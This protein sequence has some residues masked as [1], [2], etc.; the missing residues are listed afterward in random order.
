VKARVGAAARPTRPWAARRR[1]LTGHERLRPEAFAKM[2]NSLID[3]GDAGVQIMQSY[4]VKE[5]RR[6][7]FALAGTNPE[8]HIFRTCLD[9]FYQHAGASGAP[10]AHRLAATIERWWP[11][12]EAGILT[13]SSN[14]RSEGYNRLT[15]HQ[16]RNALGPKPGQA[17][18]PY[19]VGVYPPKPA[20][21]SREQRIARL[22]LRAGL[23]ST[24]SANASRRGSNRRDAA[25][26]SGRPVPGAMIEGARQHQSK[27]RAESLMI[28]IDFP[29]WGRR[30]TRELIL[31]RTRL[32]GATP[33]RL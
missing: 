8:R 16:G 10:E 20:G 25:R 26:S 13:G 22:S 4:V 23:A 24:S 6:A 21:L 27:T 31:C 9:S 29:G 30:P 12:T 11:A 17:T 3:T 32:G 14:A 5:E 19:T 7:L 28:D 18:P 2:W 1:L 33:S 15:K